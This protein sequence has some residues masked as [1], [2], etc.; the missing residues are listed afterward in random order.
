MA[1]TLL[2]NYFVMPKVRYTGDLEVLDI[3]GRSNKYSIDIMAEE[4]PEARIS[5]DLFSQ[6][7]NVL[8]SEGYRADKIKVGSKNARELKIYTQVCEVKQEGDF[9]D[10]KRKELLPPRKSH[11]EY[12]DYDYRNTLGELHFFD[13]K[14]KIEE[15][16]V[17]VEKFEYRKRIDRERELPASVKTV[18]YFRMSFDKGMKDAKYYMRSPV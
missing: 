10:A 2:I 8:P 5:R 18:P 9:S 1:K 13:C 15:H 16:T 14:G 6:K 3:D 17:P 11:N 7:L 12:D 4:I